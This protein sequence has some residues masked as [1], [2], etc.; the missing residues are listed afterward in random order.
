[1]ARRYE[2]ISDAQKKRFT[3]A[4]RSVK[5]LNEEIA[6][7]VNPR[8]YKRTSTDGKW[9]TSSLLHTRK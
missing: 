5:K 3:E 6:P 9:T 2:K 8:K 4:K 7:F 1:M